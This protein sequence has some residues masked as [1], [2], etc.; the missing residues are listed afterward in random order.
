[1]VPETS[2]I[3]AQGLAAV[4]ELQLLNMGARTRSDLRTA[5]LSIR[6]YQHS[7]EV[8]IGQGEGSPYLEDR[9]QAVASNIED[10]LHTSG[11]DAVLVLYGWDH[12]SRSMRN[13]GGPNRDQ[14]FAPAALRIEQVGVK[15]FSVVMFPLAGQSSWR[16]NH[17]DFPWHAADVHLSSG[18]ALDKVVAS[19]AQAHFI[20]ANRERVRLPI[21][22]VANY[23]VDSYLLFPSGTPLFDHCT[24]H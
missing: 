9:E 13:D 4:S 20:Y 7:F 17:W 18:E 23:A 19:A 14:P 6:A 15:T 21:N 3:K 16:G 1:M 8:G 2:E 22:E 11:I 24:T 12:V 10:L 5:E